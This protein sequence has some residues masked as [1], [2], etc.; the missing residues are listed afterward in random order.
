MN[1]AQG[2]PPILPHEGECDP[3]P[4]I[5]ADQSASSLLSFVN[6]N[7]LPE[8]EI[9][10]RNGVMAFPEQPNQTKQPEYKVEHA[11]RLFLLTH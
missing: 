11:V 1:D 6:G 7:L 4:P 9:F 2:L 5:P 10:Q 3:E 8:G